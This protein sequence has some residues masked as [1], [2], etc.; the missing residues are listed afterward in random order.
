[1]RVERLGELDV[2]AM[3][4]VADAWLALGDVWRAAK[5]TDEQLACVRIAR[6]KLAAA[7]A[8][9]HV[10]ARA[11]AIDAVVH[12]SYL[13]FVA[14]CL[15]LEAGDHEARAAARVARARVDPTGSAWA[16]GLDELGV[17]STVASHAA[18]ADA[19][20]EQLVQAAAGAPPSLAPVAERARRELKEVSARAAGPSTDAGDAADLAAA[21]AEWR[22]VTEPIVLWLTTGRVDDTVATPLVA[23]VASALDKLGRRS[24]WPT[25]VR[26]GV[27]VA[28]A[29]VILFTV[30]FGSQRRVF[31]GVTANIDKLQSVATGLASVA[32]F[33]GLAG[34]AD[35]RLR[36]LAKR[37][38]SSALGLAAIVIVCLAFASVV[39]WQSMHMVRLRARC[40]AGLQDARGEVDHQLVDVCRLDTYAS[41]NGDLLAY[42]P[43]H[44][45][46]RV[47]VSSLP[48]SLDGTVAYW[49]VQLPASPRWSARATTTTESCGVAI[50]TTRPR[51]SWSI[52]LTP[53][54]TGIV[55]LEFAAAPTQAARDATA[56]VTACFGADRALQECGTDGEYHPSGSVLE[57]SPD[58][59]SNRS[60]Y[61]VI[62]T[63]EGSQQWV[64]LASATMKVRF[65][66]NKEPLE[67]AI[68]PALAHEAHR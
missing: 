25:I 66:L 34:W 47:P 15:R 30:W 53:S 64:Q 60:A 2:V 41:T 39:L 11:R 55:P 24:N 23:P 45:D 37:I 28:T 51:A 56:V 57:L 12:A 8:S 17:C 4:A 7:L 35:E 3:I 52:V 20:V 46:M 32:G 65:V 19:I 43:G 29:L 61:R 44:E 38:V 27:L 67:E 48:H 49:I 58:C 63:V 33:L 36:T 21:R 1:M 40:E 14:E 68:V 10:D 26:V 54:V 6:E 16:W 13:A 9:D 5:L 18:R 50:D 59:A 42:A 62:V 22:A 31:V